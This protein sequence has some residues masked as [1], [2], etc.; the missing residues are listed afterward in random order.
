MPV[1]TVQ[2]SLSNAERDIG[3]MLTLTGTVDFTSSF[4]DLTSVAGLSEGVYRIINVSLC[5]YSNE[6][7]I[8]IFLPVGFLAT[9]PAFASGGFICVAIRRRLT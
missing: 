6:S 1:S 5:T 2:R 9:G 3:S 7:L 4:V 8:S